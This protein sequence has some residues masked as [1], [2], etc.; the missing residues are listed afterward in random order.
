MRT[1]AKDG[2]IA[3]IDD[4]GKFDFFYLKLL[5]G[6]LRL[7]FNLGSD[8]Q[9]IN[10]NMKINDDQWH[11]ILIRRNGQ[12]TTLSIDNGFVQ[13]STVTHSEDL[14]F[15]GAVHNEYEASPF[16]FGG[17]PAILERPSSGNLS[18][19]DVYMQTRF[20]GQLRNIIY[21][22][23]T[24][25]HLI[26][27]NQIDISGGVSLIP[28]RFCAGKNC[29]SGICLI[30]EN[31]Y[32]CLC[33]E[34]NFQGN[35]CQYEQPPN[36]LTFHGKQYLKYDLFNS[37]SSRNEILTFEFKTNHYNGLL[38]QLIDSQI[39]IKLKQGQL[40]IEYRLN[41]NS[42]YE[43]STKDL[44]LIDNQWHY[45][46][47]KRK[48]GQITM[49]IDQYYIPLDNDY[50][51]DEI[52]H[53]KEIFI[54]GNTNFH[55]EK[56]Y[57]CLKDIS[58]TFNENF[59]I[60]LNKSSTSFHEF[61]FERNL[62]CQSLINP[63]QFL[64]P[65]SFISLQLTDLFQQ[66]NI[67]FRF[68]AY[69]SNSVILYGQ[70][71]QY[72]LGLDL[73]DG[74]FYLTINVNDKQ[75]R[76]ELFQQR[77]NDGQSHYIQLNF[78][79]SQ[80]EMD[81]EITMDYRQNAKL[82][83]KDTAARM[84]LQ[85][86]T[87]GGVNPAYPLLPTNY[88]SGIMHHGLVGCFSDLEINNV[89]INLTNYINHINMNLAPRSGPCATT[90][91]KK[92][93]C[94]CEHH[95]EC[96][97]TSA[98]IWSC[99]CSKTGYTGERCEQLA[100]HIDL[101]Q[102]HTYEYNSQFQ[103]S[104]QLND[105]AFGLQAVHDEVNFLQIR[106]CR[107][108][109]KCDS[110]QFSILNGLLHISFYS[111]NLT[112]E[113]PF[114]LDNQWHSIHL[115]RFDQKF[116]LHVDNHITQQRISAVQTNSTRPS[117]IWIA[118]MGSKQVQ[119][120][121][122]RL[123][124]HSIYSKF[125]L[126]LPNETF[127]L[128][129][130][131]WKPTNTISFNDATSSYIELQLNE[132]LCQECRLDSIHFQFRT[133]DTN[134]LLLFAMVQTEDYRTNSLLDNSDSRRNQYLVLKLVN[135]Q[136]HLLIFEP[137]LSTIDSEIYQIQSK[138]FLN[139]NYWHHISIYRVSDHHFE[140]Q[141]DSN[142]YYLRTSI[143]FFDKIYLG[144][145]YEIDFLRNLPTIKGCFASFTINAQA[146]HLREYIKAN[147]PIR[148][149]CF[150]DS[151]CPLQH[152]R[153][154]GTC[155]N[156]IQ[157]DC[158][159]TS[160][161][162]RLCTN[163]KLGYSFNNHTPGLIFDQPFNKE[164]VIALYKLSFGIMTKMSLAEILR[165]NDQI[166]IELYRGYIRMKLIGNEYLVNTRII[167]D[168]FYHLVQMEC[169]LTG[170]MSITVDNKKTMKQLNNKLSFD[171]PLFLLVGQNPAFKYPFQGELY[172]LESDIYS[173]FDLISPTFHRISFA[174]VRN[175]TLKSL[176]SPILTP[177]FHAQDES[178]DHP[179][180]SYQSYDDI[181]I[182]NSEPNSTSLTYTN[183]S[184]QP[185]VPK[186]I[187]TRSPVRTF[188]T[189]IAYEDLMENSSNLTNF[190]DIPSETF[191]ERGP[192]RIRFRDLFHR[193][194]LWFFLVPLLCGSV[195]CIIFCICA[196]IKYRRKDAGVYELEETQRFRPLIVEV[197]P[198][199][200]ENIRRLINST[201]NA[202]SKQK[203]IKSHQR[204]KRKQSPLLNADE[205]R[206]FYI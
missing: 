155:L 29:G 142:K 79:H 49:L 40:L 2:T 197:P 36:E 45:V 63:I 189:T 6:K 156:R 113:Y 123:Y 134:G 130:R 139:N 41:N 34:T 91:L 125:L 87:I 66:T 205:Q 116:L 31:N 203:N 180:C 115:Q 141:I 111:I 157:C 86:L 24:N 38:F 105:I 149:D 95:G 188:T 168:G 194:N 72:F 184:N 77:I 143:D 138:T 128:K 59:T 176:S 12:S 108:S 4:R 173:I 199:P 172:G 7:L 121:D 126:N 132:I 206:E 151:Q 185:S 16:Y 44:S 171:R 106:P 96:R 32:A 19:F 70:S 118:F 50:S 145:S 127:Q 136:P 53:F 200:G 192:T 129:N 82:S 140:F 67:S 147:S 52:F 104:D 191:A 152:C 99:D 183:I 81:I 146:I 90:S 68:E 8:R 57:G 137:S 76:Q 117:T 11:T 93:Q 89:L 154:T 119:I 5:E 187:P 109:S 30:T 120:E 135:G 37:I 150:L 158:R 195:L 13:N 48:S 71:N 169:N 9:A 160:F 161:Q 83:I 65:T 165:I 42:W 61:G 62:S 179:A 163:F 101:N 54:A 69:S 181:C 84:F 100:Y 174:P 190:S 88:Y 112:I 1:N 148:N 122:L 196:F 26:Q 97:L 14:Y 17:I 35:H 133:K 204:R 94:L 46:Q 182:V 56:F 201:D 75:H 22:N 15:G 58:M 107:L 186:R 33:D 170:Y 175:R 3:Y 27:P 20:R 78:K 73:I 55:L 102:T 193:R 144:R 74:F 80:G 124:D 28:D 164:K 92:R 198:S 153:N 162:G 114:L 43:S 110:I 21:K 159:H 178:T 98:G 39:Y 51:I 64:S 18:S 10:V 167:N 60:D 166:S 85:T 23:C 47:I 131:L 25:P 103:W 177:T 202:P